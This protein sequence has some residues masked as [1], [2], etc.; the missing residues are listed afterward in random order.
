MSDDAI[1]KALSE[2]PSLGGVQD[3]YVR[4][5]AEAVEGLPFDREELEAWFIQHRVRLEDRPY[6]R[7]QLGRGVASPRA[8]KQGRSWLIPVDAVDPS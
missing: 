3:G 8:P 7:T 5:A 4:K 2:L 6:P 1:R